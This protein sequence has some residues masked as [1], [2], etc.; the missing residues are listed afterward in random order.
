MR[1]KWKI[2]NLAHMQNKIDLK[3]R[4]RVIIGQLDSL[5]S[6]SHWC[7][8]PAIGGLF[9]GFNFEMLFQYEDQDGTSYVNWC[10]G[11]VESIFNEKSNHVCVKWNEECLNPGEPSVTKEKLLSSKWNPNRATKGVW[12]QYFGGNDQ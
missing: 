10:H 8:I 12:R 9:V 6:Y 7:I 2:L 4:G 3:Q 11:V 1:M 5:V